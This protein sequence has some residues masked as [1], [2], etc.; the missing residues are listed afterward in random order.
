MEENKILISESTMEILKEELGDEVEE[1][2]EEE[3]LKKVQESSKVVATT[4]ETGQ[5]QI[6]Q[7]LNG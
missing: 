4:T 5:T 3:L 7:S 6:R 1:L 2:E